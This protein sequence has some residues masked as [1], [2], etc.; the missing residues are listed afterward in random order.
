MAGLKG[1][2]IPKKKARLKV[3]RRIGNAEVDWTD[4]MELTGIQYHKKRTAAFQMYYREFK[5]ADLV[6]SVYT[7]MKKN[8]YTSD[9]IKF[10]KNGKVSVQTSIM[11]RCLVNGMPDL[12]EAHNTYWKGLDGTMSD[13]KPVSEYVI[14]AVKKSIKYGKDRV[15][16]EKEAVKKYKPTIKQVMTSTS[17][18]MASR[19]DDFVEGF[20]DGD[21]TLKI[22][23]FDPVKILHEVQAKANHARIIKSFYIH[24]YDDFVKL[25]GI[26]KSSELKNM[27]EIEQDE[28]EQIGE[29]YNHLSKKQIKDYTT[30]Y[31]KIINACDIITAESKST[32]KP[33]ITKP[34]SPDKLVSKLKFKASD[35][36]YGIASIPPHKLVGAVLAVIF[37]CKTRKLGVYVA[38]DADG[39]TVKGTS[40]KR[41]DENKSMQRTVRKPENLFSEY[42]RLTK[43]RSLKM[44]N[45]LTT[46]EKKLNGRFNIDTILLAVFE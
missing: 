37:N 38:E 15:E 13:I 2:K 6:V 24:T 29:N 34:K 25:N 18:S 27:S 21:K 39:F 9:E 31:T 32:R 17:I 46:T 28:W 1:I 35:T 3:R 12:H 33:R 22:A 20:I 45:S 42:K 19:I 10:A 5:P 16:E 41:F 4:S 43:P 23:K 44:F 8:G 26:P 7:W 11:A 36:E 30:I 14:Y 40:L